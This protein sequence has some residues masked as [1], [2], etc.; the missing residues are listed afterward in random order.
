[1]NIVERPGSKEESGPASAG[2]DIV[3]NST[4]CGRVQNLHRSLSIENSWIVAA[5]ASVDQTP[6]MN[7]KLNRRCGAAQ[8]NNSM[9]WNSSHSSSFENSF[10]GGSLLS[11]ESFPKMRVRGV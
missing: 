2:V 1:M 11:K 9:E 7:Q 8:Q 10:C 5:E 6:V 3:A 4:S